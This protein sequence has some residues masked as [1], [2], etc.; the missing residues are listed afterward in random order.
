MT[1]P[2]SEPDD[3]SEDE[4]LHREVERLLEMW[5]DEPTFQKLRKGGAGWS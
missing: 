1:S 3:L 4:L 2:S 5:D